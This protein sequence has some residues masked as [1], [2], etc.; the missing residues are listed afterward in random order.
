MPNLTDRI[1]SAW[2]AFQNKDPTWNQIVADS[3]FVWSGNSYRADR[4]R[5]S[6]GNERS[7]I[8]SIYNRIAIDVASVQIEHVKLDDDGRYRETIPS[9]INKVLTVE[10][11]IDQTGREFMQDAVMSRSFGKPGLCPEQRSNAF[12]RTK[13]GI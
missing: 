8:N 5:L 9:K 13:E 6:R 4:V 11:N 12:V 7:I 3:R 2:N 10:A 1:R